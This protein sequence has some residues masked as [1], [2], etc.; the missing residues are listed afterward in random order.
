MWGR[1]ILRDL[2]AL[3]AEV[4]V[5]EP[6]QA[7]REAALAGG[8][9]AVVADLG[10]LPDAAGFI[11]ATPAVTH[12]GVVTT[13]LE[14]RRPMLVEKPLTTDI[15]S[16]QR[17]AAQGGGLLFVGHIWRYHAGVQ[18]LGEIARSG[19]LGPVL[20]VRSTRTN[21]T[22]PRID[23]DSIWNMAPHDLTLAIEILGRIPQPR[24][25]LAEIHDGRPV[26]MTA[27]LGASPW[28]VFEVSN[29][30]RDKRREVRLHCR[31]GVAV[32]PDLEGGHIEVIRGD[33]V[34]PPAAMKVETRLYSAESA[35]ERELKAFL[36]F[37]G[38]GPPPKSDA[39]EGLEVVKTLVELRKL[40]G[41]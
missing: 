20:G 31:D 10:D 37:I 8:A 25:A 14:R 16:A 38:G 39:A 30:Y 18:L 1:L 9:N 40:A 7:A 26:G 19:Q 23:V 6:N 21:W 17:L 32:L 29:R 15:A 35:L 12:A 34:T 5:V 41:A 3:G 22:S 2:L 13:L 33:A 28:L 27:L 24:A 36:E 11:V 4:F